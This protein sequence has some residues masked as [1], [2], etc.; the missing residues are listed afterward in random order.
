[1]RTLTALLALICTCVGPAAAEPA[2]IDESIRQTMRELGIQYLI[3]EDRKLPKSNRAKWEADLAD[4]VDFDSLN[5]GMRQRIVH[6]LTANS[7][8]LQ[9]AQGERLAQKAVLFMIPRQLSDMTLLYLRQREN[10]GPLAACSAAFRPPPE[11]ALA[12]CIQAESADKARVRFVASSGEFAAALVF[13]HTDRWRLIDIDKPIT[14][15]ELSLIAR[16][17]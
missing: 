1:M 13:E 15:R 5:A 11:Q 2:K 6:A 9:P 12:L 10:G 17:K 3:S 8:E 16:W 14:E 4:A 7:T